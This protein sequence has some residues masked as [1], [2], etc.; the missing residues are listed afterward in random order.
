MLNLQAL[1]NNQSSFSSK[2]FLS[3][4]F[5]VPILKFAMFHLEWFINIVCGFWK[6]GKYITLVDL[7]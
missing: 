3:L 4:N 1:A 5:A 7:T 6:V 2:N